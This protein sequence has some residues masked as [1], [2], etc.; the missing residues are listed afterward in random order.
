[1][2]ISLHI[3]G[4]EVL[5]IGVDGLPDLLDGIGGGAGDEG[6]VD[7]DLTPFGFV[8]SDDEDEDDRARS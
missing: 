3:L 7:P 2:K 8:G 6:A 1:M 4:T 5:A